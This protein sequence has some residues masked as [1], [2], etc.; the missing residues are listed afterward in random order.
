M[1]GS[2]GPFELPED[3]P[4]PLDDGAADH[5]T[6][7][8]MPSIRL[9][10]TTGDW[11]DVSR[12]AGSAVIY[13]YPMTGD[14]KTPL[15]AG[16][17]QIPGARGCTPES[18]AFDAAEDR[19]RALGAAVF[20]LSTQDTD[21][22]REMVGRLGLGFPVLSDAQMELT[23]ALRLPTMNVAGMTLL[24]RLTMIVR[25]GVIVRVFYPVFPPTK[26]PEEV[27]AWL[28]DHPGKTAPAASFTG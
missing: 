12:L 8:K 6:G 19:I 14:P 28:Q 21:Y 13:L 5:L 10:A 27:I 9:L 22:Q 24:R 20:G 3:L 26:A 4:R 17:D 23:R 11:M 18:L 15:P 25:D 1:V 16:W 2:A 7:R